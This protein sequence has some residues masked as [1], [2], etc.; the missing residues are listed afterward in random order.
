M[1]SCPWLLIDGTHPWGR[2]LLVLCSVQ[3]HDAHSLDALAHS[4][5]QPKCIFPSSGKLGATKKPAGKLGLGIKKLENKVDE[6]LF[7]QAP[8]APEPTPVKLTDLVGTPGSAGS[9]ASGADGKGFSRFS[10]ATLNEVGRKA[11]RCTGWCDTMR[12]ACSRG[13][14]DH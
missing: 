4:L 13:D 11:Y 5:A 9:T 1:T 7:D 2:S 12:L 6:S 14:T 3:S 8:A 10:Y